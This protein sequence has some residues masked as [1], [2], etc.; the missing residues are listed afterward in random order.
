MKEHGKKLRRHFAKTA[1]TNEQVALLKN[2][3]ENEMSKEIL[4][5]YIPV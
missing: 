2:L 1:E 3:H 5:M 4:E